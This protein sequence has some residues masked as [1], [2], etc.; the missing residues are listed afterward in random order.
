[1]GDVVP[2]TK[3]MWSKKPSVRAKA[4]VEW[5]KKRAQAA[6]EAIG[7]QADPYMPEI[8]APYEQSVTLQD[9]A[10]RDLDGVLVWCIGQ[11]RVE[12]EG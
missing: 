5:R 4:F 11:L 7:Q 3:S 10:L 9:G 12:D 8:A 1:M 6:F 2:T